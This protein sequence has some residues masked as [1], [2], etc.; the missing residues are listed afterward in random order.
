[1]DTTV[2]PAASQ[3]S[4]VCPANDFSVADF[5][6]ALIANVP[7]ATTGIGTSQTARLVVSLISSSRVPLCRMAAGDTAAHR[8]SAQAM[9]GDTALGFA[10]AITAGD[11][12]SADVDHL[13]VRV[14]AEP[15]QRVVQDRCRPG[16]VERRLGD[17]VQ[18]GGFVEVDID[19]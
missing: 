7:P 12:L 11:P 15:R 14:G 18:R 6:P 4:I 5:A 19:A 9:L 2:L 8:T 1:P 17:R 16:R 13:R 10:G 3:T